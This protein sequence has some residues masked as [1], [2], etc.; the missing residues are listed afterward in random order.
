LKWLHREI[1]LSAAYRQASHPRTDG[2]E[3]DPANRLLWRMNPRRLDIEAYRDA[4]LQAAGR[5]DLTLYGP[6]VHPEESSRRTVYA[7]IGR[8]SLNSQPLLAMYDFPE[9]FEHSPGR[10]LTTTPLQQLFVLN[11]DFVKEQAKALAQA[12]EG[13]SSNT[14][15]VRG[16]F[17]KILAREPSA[18]ELDL[19]LSYLAQAKTE[20]YAQMLLATNEVIFWP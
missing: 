3:A 12:V 15:K 7:R 10:T 9:P 8:V 2:Q 4:L 13:E 18:A 1:M 6:S 5:L 17:R 16:L 20:E 11:S 19:A 14:D